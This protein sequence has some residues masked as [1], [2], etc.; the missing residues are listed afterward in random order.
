MP[1]KIALYLIYRLEDAR[2]PFDHSVLPFRI[3]Q[4]VPVEDASA[5]FNADTFAWA[6]NYLGERHLADLQGVR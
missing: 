4:G 1:N 2:Q 5:M 6:R 3:T